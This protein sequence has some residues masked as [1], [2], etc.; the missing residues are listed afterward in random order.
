VNSPS[1]IAAAIQALLQQR[2]E[3]KSVCPSDVARA[4][5]PVDWRDL[6]EPVR[7]VARELVT[8]GKLRITQKG[9]DLDPAKVGG[10][11]R[12]RLP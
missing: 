11:I 3:G 6:M 7:A 4:L 10:A 2:G 9:K 5:D 12:L 1:E 8:K